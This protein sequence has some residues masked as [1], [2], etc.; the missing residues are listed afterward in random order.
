[1]A[2]PL[3][4]AKLF[5]PRPWRGAV[6]RP[7]LRERLGR[8][9]ES[10]LTLVSAPAGFGKT[11]MLAEWLHLVLDDYHLVDGPGVQAG[12]AYLL[13]HL[14]ANSS[15]HARSAPRSAS[16]RARLGPG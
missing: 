15:C 1:M 13:E 3:V 14:C 7:R 11:P 2:G 5:V 6:S 16:N 8:G 10:R 4:A 12:M 9:S